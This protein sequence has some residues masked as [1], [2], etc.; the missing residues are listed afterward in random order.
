[1]KTTARELR[2]LQSILDD[3]V[4]APALV[5]LNKRQQRTI[6]DELSSHKNIREIRNHIL[7]LDAARRAPIKARSA[8]RAQTPAG[9]ES[10]R[11]YNVKR[12]EQRA[13]ARQT[14]N[15]PPGLTPAILEARVTAAMRPLG[16]DWA[17]PPGWDEAA[18]RRNLRRALIEAQTTLNEIMAIPGMAED[19]IKL[20]AQEDGRARRPAS[21]FYYH[22]QAHYVDI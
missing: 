3:S 14:R 17:K 9:Q 5:R 10:R 18:Y 11:K 2:R 21:P 4:L 6:L 13:V 22:F 16:E 1:M 19:V 12:R 7:E 15:L 20:K 8:Q